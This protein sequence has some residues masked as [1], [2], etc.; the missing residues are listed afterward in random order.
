VGTLLQTYRDKDK[1]APLDYLKWR[2]HIMSKFKTIALK[3]GVNDFEDDLY[4]YDEP[5]IANRENLDLSKINVCLHQIQGLWAQGAMK[6]F[7]LKFYY[8]QLAKKENSEGREFQSLEYYDSGDTYNIIDYLQI[9]HVYDYM[10]GYN[11][12]KIEVLDP[13]RHDEVACDLIVDLRLISA[14]RFVKKWFQMRNEN[15]VD[16]VESYR[17]PFTTIEISFFLQSHTEVQHNQMMALRNTQMSSFI[18]SIKRKLP[19][20]IDIFNKKNE[21]EFVSLM[22]NDFERIVKEELTM[23]KQFLPEQQAK[24][25]VNDHYNYIADADFGNI[26]FENLEYLVRQCFFVEW[27]DKLKDVYSLFIQE[28]NG[29]NQPKSALSYLMDVYQTNQGTQGKI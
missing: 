20:R 6:L 26:S 5:D 11:S 14:N 9:N 18:S 1:K 16:N 28:K 24:N 15:M 13:Q 10:E 22:K 12:I 21:N 4:E 29:L 17:F 27:V 25:T 23:L 7:K 8:G 3:E 19:D 2:T